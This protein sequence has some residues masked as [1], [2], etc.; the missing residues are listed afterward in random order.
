[1]TAKKGTV[2][3]GPTKPEKT[4]KGDKVYTFK[5]K[6]RDDKVVLFKRGEK[7]IDGTTKVISEM[8][9]FDRNTWTTRDPEK[10]ERLRQIIKERERDRNPLHVFETTDMK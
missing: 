2:L 3:E 6:Y 1:M 10:A 7:R 5:S 4:D 9:E 8:A